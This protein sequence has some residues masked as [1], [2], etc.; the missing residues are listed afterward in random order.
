MT[1]QQADEIITA[2]LDRFAQGRMPKELQLDVLEAAEKR[3]AP[4]IQAKLESIAADF[5]KEDEMAPYQVALFGGNAEDGKKIFFERPE[6]ACSR[7]HKIAGQGS[8]GGAVGPE[9]TLIGAQ[10]TR[11]HILESLVLPNKQ[12]A[13]G[14]ESLIIVTKDGTSYV[15]IAQSENDSQLVLNS[16]EDGVVTIKKADITVRERGLSSMPEG[17]TAILSKRDLRDLVE[18][19]A[20]NS[21]ANAGSEKAGSAEAA[22]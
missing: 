16:P 17:L 15:G 13:T 2:W 19:L 20:T 7:C 18:F 6:A 3:P 14:F 4:A 22:N 5:A 9:L 10:R 11:E 8:E 21:H 1:N 12:I